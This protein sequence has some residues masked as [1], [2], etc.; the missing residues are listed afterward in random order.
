MCHLINQRCLALLLVAWTLSGQAAE[1]GLRQSAGAMRSAYT[2][3]TYPLTDK[4]VFI[5]HTLTPFIDC[6]S[7]CS[8]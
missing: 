8:A 1:P 6:Y 4:R 5:N 7:L 2:G 3:W